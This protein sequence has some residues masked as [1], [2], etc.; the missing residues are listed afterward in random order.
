LK[1]TASG[2]KAIPLSPNHTKS[3]HEFTTSI[4]KAIKKLP[5]INSLQNRYCDWD[6]FDW[7]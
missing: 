2:L 4:Y 5:V 7:V 3:Y 6:L 1:S